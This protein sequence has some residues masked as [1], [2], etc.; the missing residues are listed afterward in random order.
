MH[1]KHYNIHFVH[2]HM[3]ALLY[4]HK[5]LLHTLIHRLQVQLWAA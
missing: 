1:S 4:L 3:L 5:G 2:L